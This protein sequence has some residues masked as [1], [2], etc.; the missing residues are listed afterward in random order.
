MIRTVG[1]NTPAAIVALAEKSPPA[2]HDRFQLRTILPKMRF[3]TAVGFVAVF[4]VFHFYRAAA[5]GVAVGFADV[6]MVI[7]LAW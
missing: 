6:V 2:L 7:G 4:A 3:T 5:A 1:R